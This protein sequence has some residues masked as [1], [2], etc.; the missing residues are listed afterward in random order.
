MSSE[1]DAQPDRPDARA[2]SEDFVEPSGRWARAQNNL[3]VPGV[4]VRLAGSD[5]HHIPERLTI[6]T[7]DRHTDPGARMG[8]RARRAA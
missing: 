4:L 7:V 1:P 8:Q 5:P 2:E 3:C 6:Y